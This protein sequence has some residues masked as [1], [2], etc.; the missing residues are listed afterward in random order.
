MLFVIVLGCFITGIVFLVL[1]NRN[2]LR[3]DGWDIAGTALTIIGTILLCACLVVLGCQYLGVSGQ[4]ASHNQ[5]YDMLTY[6][7]ENNLYDN[8]NDLGKKELMNQIQA[9]NEDLAWYKTNQNDFWIGIFIPDIYDQF[10]FI[11]LER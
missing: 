8:D 3:S 7:Y 1:Y 4:I 2:V 9:W 10:E 11:A 6:Q 5:R